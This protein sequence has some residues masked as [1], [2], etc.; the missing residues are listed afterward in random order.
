MTK[1]ANNQRGKVRQAGSDYATFF[2]PRLHIMLPLC[3]CLSVFPVFMRVLVLL[4]DIP[5]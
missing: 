4:D 1:E 5:P 3:V 2:T